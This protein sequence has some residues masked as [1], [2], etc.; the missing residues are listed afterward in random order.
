MCL[1]GYFS[2]ILSK[3]NEMGS[4]PRPMAS[5]TRLTDGCLGVP[6]GDVPCT[7][8][9]GCR[10]AAFGATANRSLY[11]ITTI[12]EGAAAGVYMRLG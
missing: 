2:V 8:R 3:I 4:E 6:T 9:P 10:A 1:R 11:R 5:V 7:E 12:S